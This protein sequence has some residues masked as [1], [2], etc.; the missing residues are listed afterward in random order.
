[1]PLF[2]GLDIGTTHTKLIV[3]DPAVNILF[4]AKIGY[5]KGFGD[6]LDC[7]EILDAVYS[8]LKKAAETGVFAGQE[9]VVTFST[10]MHSLVL[11]NEAAEPLTPLYT[12]ADTSSQPVVREL[13]NDPL[14]QQLFFETGTP[15][16][17]M[18]PLCKLAW[19]K[20][21]SPGL[22]AG[23]FKATGIKEF[24]WY[25][26]TGRW[27]ADHSIASATG[28]F[29]QKTMYWHPDA[30]QIA[31]LRLDQLAAPVPVTH[32]ASASPGGFAAACSLPEDTSWVI[33][34]SDGV[35]AQLGSG[36]LAKGVA[37]LTIGTSGA[38]RVTIP[39]F[40]VDR[41]RELFTY[42]LDKE[43]SVSGG[44]I[45]NGGIVLQ[46]W[47]RQ[48][49]ELSDDLPTA[50]E[51]FT[52]SAASVMPGCEG[53][54]CLPWFGGERAPVWDADATGIFA[55]VK[56]THGQSHFKRSII[57]GICFSFR[58]LLEK[59]EAAHGP[60]REVYASGGFTGS[61]W[62]VQVM[63]DILERPLVIRDDADASA[64]GAVAVG[65]KAVGMIRRW[66]DF[67]ALSDDRGEAYHPEVQTKNTYFRNYERFLRL[68]QL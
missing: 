24:I 55:G 63:A 50:L 3:C 43:H 38:I 34:G 65:M 21:S 16:H 41:N 44:A 47:Q 26:V 31:G 25:Q 62:W 12:W 53:L 52:T 23:A 39:D 19:M 11:L 46:W 30:M 48:V 17:P 35:L 2:A 57:E 14:V 18:S 58:V 9:L 28:L 68:C 22:L 45:N 60:V 8:L 7:A 59:L 4:Q 64:L 20:R 40:T 33:G 27:E 56:N 15:F 37:A 36:A 29:S 54:V 32:T 61:K 42:H 13:E 5:S 6:T 51:K 66:E 1:M 10:A 49:M 67:P